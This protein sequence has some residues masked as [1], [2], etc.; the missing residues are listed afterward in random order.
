MSP[1]MNGD[2]RQME[3][4]LRELSKGEIKRKEDFYNSAYKSEHYNSSVRKSKIYKVLT[5]LRV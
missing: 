4:L 2:L 1:T 3:N 5:T